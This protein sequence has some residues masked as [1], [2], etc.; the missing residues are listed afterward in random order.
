VYVRQILL[1]WQQRNRILA[2]S[3]AKNKNSAKNAR[4]HGGSGK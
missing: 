4:S 1:E 2:S 3:V